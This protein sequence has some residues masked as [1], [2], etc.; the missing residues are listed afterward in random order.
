M[1]GAG[2]K[3]PARS[4]SCAKAMPM[5]WILC[6]LFKRWNYK[7]TTKT[8]HEGSKQSNHHYA[9]KGSDLNP[10]KKEFTL[11]VMNLQREKAT[12]AQIP[13]LLPTHSLLPEQSQAHAHFRQ[14]SGRRRKAGD[15]RGQSV[16]RGRGL[17]LL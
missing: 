1:D 16:A 13:D 8:V 15:D 2:G 3:I 9:P 12:L 7:S 5:L 4:K 11:C 17:R 6:K 14:L 10:Y